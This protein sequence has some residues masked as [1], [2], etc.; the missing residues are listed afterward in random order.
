[1]YVVMNGKLS[2]QVDRGN[3]GRNDG[4]AFRPVTDKMRNGPM[5]NPDENNGQLAIDYFSTNRL[6]FHGV[7]A[8]YS[9]LF[10]N[11]EDELCRAS[12]DRVYTPQESLLL[13]C[14]G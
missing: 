1:M 10:S 7:L 13:R 12:R 4:M 14:W 6:D 11:I 3:S 9:L 8:Q 2:I 5:N